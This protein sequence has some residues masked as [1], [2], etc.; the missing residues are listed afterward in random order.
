MA[1]RSPESYTEVVTYGISR[2]ERWRSAS[3][4]DLLNA[5]HSGRSRASAATLCYAVSIQNFSF[6]FGDRHQVR[7]VSNATQ[8]VSECHPSSTA[9]QTYIVP[10]AFQG[11][12]MWL[13]IT[14]SLVRPLEYAKNPT[15][16][17]ICQK[18]S[19]LCLVVDTI[20]T[21]GLPDFVW[22]YRSVA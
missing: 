15:S 20:F 6:S 1:L 9:I 13:L 12:S 22:P 21:I 11:I 10:K 19:L 7:C 17:P 5:S 2:P 16:R 14:A 18:S 3:P 4:S 8:S